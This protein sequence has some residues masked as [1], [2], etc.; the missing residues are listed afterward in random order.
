MFPRPPA[1][2]SSPQHASS[3]FLR[4]KSISETCRSSH[5][6]SVSGNGVQPLW[7]ANHPGRENLASQVWNPNE[8]P[9]DPAHLFHVPGVLHPLSVSRANVSSLLAKLRGKPDA[10]SSSRRGGD[11]E[12]GG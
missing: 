1:L 10:H 5:G 2:F 11:V 9:R 3:T 4:D 12:P 8:A 7:A 6:A